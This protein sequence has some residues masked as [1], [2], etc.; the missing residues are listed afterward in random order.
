MTGQ[1]KCDLIRQVTSYK[2]FKFIRNFLW[3][4][5]KRWPYNTGDLLQGVKFIGNFLWQDRKRWPYNTGD[6]LKEVTAKAGL[7]VLYHCS[8]SVISY[9]DK[10]FHEEQQ[11]LVLISSFW[12]IM[13]VF[14]HCCWQT[15]VIVNYKQST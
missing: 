5:R 4:D 11:L 6:C 13:C 14:I 15:L 3:Q 10:V 2:W 1:E 7:T 9:F 12:Y 8:I